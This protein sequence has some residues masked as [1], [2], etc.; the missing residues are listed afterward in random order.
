MEMEREKLDLSLSAME[1]LIDDCHNALELGNR[2]DHVA[3]YLL[4]CLGILQDDLAF[5]MR[6]KGEL[7]PTVEK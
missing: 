4:G 6:T 2:P 7:P 1:H 3:Y 5:V